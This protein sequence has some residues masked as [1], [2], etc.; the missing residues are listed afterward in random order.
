MQP[1][2]MVHAL[3]QIHDLLKPGGHL[4]DVHPTGEPVK[5]IRPLDGYEHFIGN[6]QETDD[7]IEYQ[8]AD[9]A[10]ETAV[11]KGLFQVR[12]TKE[13]N[14]HTYANSFENLKTFLKENWSD[15]VIPDDVIAEAQKLDKEHGKHTVFL[16]EH[17]RVTVL[18]AVSEDC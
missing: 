12:E 18:K 13:F 4:I 17:T 1:E 2:S 6:L 5:F 7:Y 8:Q 14:F 3:E 11:S 9:D 10:L 16:R 15:A